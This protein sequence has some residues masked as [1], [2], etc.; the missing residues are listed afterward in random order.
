MRKDKLMAVIRG[1]QPRMTEI[2]FYSNF[3]RIKIR[4]I[5]D[6]KTG[7]VVEEKIPKNVE[8]INLPLKPAWF[9]DPIIPFL[10]PLH[11]HRSWKYLENLEKYLKDVDVINISDMFYFYSG[12]CA[13]LAKKLNKKLVAV[14]WENIPNHLSTYIPPYSFNVRAVLKNADL[15]IARS[16]GSVLYLR[17]IG[18]E[19]NKIK[20]IYKGTDTKKFYPDFNYKTEKIRILYVGQLVSS[21]G[22]DELTKAFIKLSEEFDNLE[23]W[24]C[25]RSAGEPLEEKIKELSKKYNIRL[26]GHVSYDRLPEIYKQCQIYCQLS[27]DWKY[28]GILKGGNEWFPYTT[29]EAMAS[30]LPVV[31]TNVGGM[32]EQLGNENILVKQKDVNSTYKG[33]KELILNPQ[34]RLLIGKKNAQRAKDLFDIRNQAEKTEEAILEVL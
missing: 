29:I 15:F 4:A 16:W 27:Q 2:N 19:E 11:A 12:Q 33:L 31:A 9:F 26:L 30:G 21:K 1:V 3:K 6:K 5:G 32:P 34:K 7:W 10:G 24:I 13:H 18:V 20:M 23:L 17:S 22:V 8:Y 28:F 25:Q 14:I